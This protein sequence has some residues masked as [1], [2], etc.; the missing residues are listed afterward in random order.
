MGDKTNLLYLYSRK[1]LAEAKFKKLMVGFNGRKRFSDMSAEN[2]QVRIQFTHIAQPD[3]LRGR[4]FSMVVMDE[5]V[6]LTDELTELLEA[7]MHE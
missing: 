7:Q 4:R 3:Q 5:Y 1:P 6:E 2:D